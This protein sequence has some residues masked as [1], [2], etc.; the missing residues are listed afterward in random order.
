MNV[1]SVFDGMSCGQL[2]LRSAGINYDTYFAS[3]IEDS[4]IK[5][6]KK[7]FPNTVHLG[8]VCGVR[9]EE[10][11]KIDLFIGGSPC[12]SFSPAI[13]TNTGFDGKSQ[14]FFEWLRLLRETNPRYFLL[15][16]VEMRKEWEKV[17]TDL[18]GVQP[19]RINS[20]YFC[21]QSRPRLYWTNIP[22]GPIPNSQQVLGDILEP[23]VAPKYFYNPDI[24]VTPTNS[25]GPVEY[26]L[27]VKG[28]ELMRRVS[29][30][31]HKV[32]CLTAICGG[33][34]HAKVMDG[35][36][37]RRLT[38]IEYERA[39]MVPDN[40]TEGVSDSARYKMIGNGWTVGVIAHILSGINTA[41]L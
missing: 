25:G 17:I 23:S 2:A 27:H 4:S 9:A 11:P 28:H 5:I 26:L 21:A 38:P 1:L 29:S 24:P 7:N 32:R 22:V 3:E 33:N 16:N 18:V 12:Q 34:Q 15:E 8:D 30:R 39:Q 35:G 36:K 14:L 31:S 40:Y 19:L 10:L 20:Q 37:V 6:T 13:S 41:S